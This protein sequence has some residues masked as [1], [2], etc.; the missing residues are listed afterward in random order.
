[1]WGFMKTQSHS[2]EQ[3]IGKT[4]HGYAVSHLLGSGKLN[5]VYAA[6]QEISL[7]PALLTVFLVPDSFSPEAL[8][9]FRQ[10]FTQAADKLAHLDHPHI[11]PVS[12]Y[13]E[14]YGYPYLVTPP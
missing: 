10:R 5:A 7:R 1:M 6:Q 9:R 8:A 3:L 11:L 4:L 13:G 14:E 2:V 12:V